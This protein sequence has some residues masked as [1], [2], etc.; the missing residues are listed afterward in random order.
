MNA[1][2]Y[3]YI[4]IKSDM[5][6]YSDTKHL[7]MKLFVYMCMYTYTLIHTLYMYICTS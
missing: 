1:M 7:L 5:E 6:I 3:I 2:E 4:Y